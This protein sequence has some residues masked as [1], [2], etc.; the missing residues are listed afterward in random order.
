MNDAARIPVLLVRYKGS[1]KLVLLSFPSK[2]IIYYLV[3]F[4]YSNG[5]DKF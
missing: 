4:H 3:T 5:K 2:D 1:Y